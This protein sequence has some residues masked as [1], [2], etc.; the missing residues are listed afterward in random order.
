M[1]R[2]ERRKAQ[3]RKREPRVPREHNYRKPL[4]EVTVAA[5]ASGLIERGRVTIANVMHDEWCDI[6][7][8]GI[9]NCD[10]IIEMQPLAR[11]E[12]IN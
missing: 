3:T 5:M 10:P 9:C 6:D 8:D 7:C 1:N 4:L 12:E 2:H 11:P